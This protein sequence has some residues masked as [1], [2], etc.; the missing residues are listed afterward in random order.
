MIY[1]ELVT[2]NSIFE[3]TVSQNWDINNHKQKKDR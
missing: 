1:H 3:D 2:Q